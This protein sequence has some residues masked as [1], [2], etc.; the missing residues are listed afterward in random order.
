M[1]KIVVVMK[2]SQISKKDMSATLSQMEKMIDDKLANQKVFAPIL[3][4]VVTSIIAF[5]FVQNLG[6]DVQTVQLFMIV[7][8]Y[9]LLCFA[10]LLLTLFGKSDYSAKVKKGRK[11]FQPHQLST[12]CNLSDEDY[13]GRLTNY[14][15]RKLTHEESLSAKCIKR[16]I[17]EYV[18]KKSCLNVV[19]VI[20]M[21]GVMILGVICFLGIFIA[22]KLLSYDGGM[23]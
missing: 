18:F 13:L 8:C 5:L 16:K 22:P 12:Y 9:A 19:L 11:P 3:L 20:I 15:G 10:I 17:N 14:A 21:A 6:S 4:T 7:F 1:S 2:R 23:V